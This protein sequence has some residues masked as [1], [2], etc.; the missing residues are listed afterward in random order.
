[1]TQTVN[2]GTFLQV[3]RIAEHLPDFHTV[4]LQKDYRLANGS[5]PH[6]MIFRLGRLEIANRVGGF[7]LQGW[8]VKADTIV[9]DLVM[10]REI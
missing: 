6:L 3:F 1:M 2:I 4:V 5:L 8:Q 10:K 7:R 9:K